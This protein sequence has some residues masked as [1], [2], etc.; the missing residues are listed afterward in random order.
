MNE[1][2]LN[3]TLVISTLSSG[4]AERVLVLLAEGLIA[5][6]HRVTVVT[7]SAQNSDFYQLPPEASRLALGIMSESAN[8]IEGLIANIQRIG[9]LKR[10]LKST[11]PNVVISFL[12]ITNICTILACFGAKY[13]VIVT[14]HNDPQ[15]FSY[16]KIWETLRRWTYPQSSM[17]VSVSKGVDSSL[18]PLSAN[19]RAVI[20]NPI[21]IVEK[22]QSD[23]LPESVDSSKNWIVSMGRLTEQKGF[24]LLLQAFGKI[25]PLFPDWQLLILGKGELREELENQKN[26]LGL[27]NKVVFTGA[28]TNPV[29]VLKQAKFFVMASRNEGFPM[30]HGEALACG[31]PVIATDCPSGPR[32][33]IRHEIDGILIPNGDVSALATAMKSL[34]TDEQKRRRL[35]AKAPEV[36]QRFNLERIVEEWESLMYGL[37]KEK[38]Q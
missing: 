8:P 24:D 16:G 19:K 23:R 18:K 2:K 9:S 11:K 1:D 14:E 25:A 7:F 26:A 15:V 28:L 27:T 13:P 32:E 30:A 3:I 34:I 33:M 17:V 6:G 5:Q 37:I 10:A 31:L 4:G 35:A 12:R 38:I 29:R 21:V 36:I 20:Y 22:T